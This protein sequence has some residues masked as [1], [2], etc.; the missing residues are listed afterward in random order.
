[1][2]ATTRTANHRQD[3]L[4]QTPCSRSF[5]HPLNANIVVTNANEQLQGNPYSEMY[6]AIAHIP[7]LRYPNNVLK[8]SDYIKLITTSHIR[9]GS[10]KDTA[11]GTHYPM[12]LLVRNYLH[13][14]IEMEGG[15]HISNLWA[16]SLATCDS[17]AML[18]ALP[19]PAFRTKL[20]PRVTFTKRCTLSHLMAPVT[21][22][23]TA[24][25]GHSKGSTL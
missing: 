14:R 20:G 6:R 19:P 13:S 12:V 4:V 16:F 8:V 15:E 3:D 7:R 25:V 5:S 11:D 18:T 17:S 1:M 9:A 2:Y 21:K 24:S 22:L 23:V 10:R